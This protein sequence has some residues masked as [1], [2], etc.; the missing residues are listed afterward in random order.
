MT[1]S[2][3]HLLSF[4]DQAARAEATR[5]AQVVRQRWLKHAD[6]LGLRAGEADPVD[7]GPCPFELGMLAMFRYARGDNVPPFIVRSFIDEL[8]ELMF[9]GLASGALA[10]PSWQ[11]MED[12]PWAAAWR[13]AE[14]RLLLESEDAPELQQLAYLLGVK[15]H[16]LEERLRAAGVSL[17]QGRAR[18]EALRPILREWLSGS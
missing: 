16:T 5:L 13:A 18:A 11:K 7:D 3:R 14:L 9:A 4:D 15:P 2:T 17:D 6:W 12:R 8:L 1:A 10:L